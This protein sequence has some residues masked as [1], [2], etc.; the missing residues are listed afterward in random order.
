[1]ATMPFDILES[2]YK[3]SMTDAGPALV[4]GDWKKVSPTVIFPAL[5]YHD[6]TAGRRQP[7]SRRQDLFRL[8][9]AAQREERH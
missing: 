2:L 7:R 1:M 5:G 9:Q 4:L 8:P 3:R 6:L